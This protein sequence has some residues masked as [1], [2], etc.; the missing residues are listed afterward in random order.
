MR[1]AV[2][3]NRDPCKV[4]YST[5]SIN[6]A[7]HYVWLAS[8]YSLIWGR[9]PDHIL[10]VSYIGE[11]EEAEP[12]YYDLMYARSYGTAVPTRRPRDAYA[13]LDHGEIVW[14]CNAEVQERAHKW[15]HHEEERR[16]REMRKE[17]RMH[18]EGGR[19]NARRWRRNRYHNVLVADDPVDEDIPR[20]R[21][22]A[23]VFD[24]WYEDV[25]FR[26]SKSWKDQ[27]K[28]QHQWRPVGT[29]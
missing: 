24:W 5:D 28:R 17:A 26:I 15:S 14:L 25:C 1:Y 6:E 29:C 7:C 13:I 21:P 10:L 3:Y 18:G 8:R 20:L 22:G 12:S 19:R 4:V 27:S 2:V 11:D 16:E 23:R 9:R